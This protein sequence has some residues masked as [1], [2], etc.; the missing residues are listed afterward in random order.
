MQGGIRDDAM[1]MGQLD[2]K[3]NSSTW[4][5]T[6]LCLNAKGK[7]VR[8]LRTFLHKLLHE[9]CEHEED[10]AL[11]AYNDM[12]KAILEAERDVKRHLQ[13]IQLGNKGLR[14]DLEK[15]R[16]EFLQIEKD[17]DREIISLQEVCRIFYFEKKK[18]FEKEI[19]DL[20][21]SLLQS[22]TD[23]FSRERSTLLNQLHRFFLKSVN[24][25]STIF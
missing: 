23:Q 15:R 8:D 14:I 7:T 3:E 6:S 25:S 19:A 9:S 13:Q 2:R 5:L 1:V 11:I 20:R 24:A 17:K 12:Q 18:N 21:A 16:F 10:V 4:N 22:K